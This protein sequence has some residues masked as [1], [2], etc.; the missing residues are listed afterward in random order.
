MADINRDTLRH[1]E[2]PPI[3]AQATDY[4]HPAAISVLA[5]IRGAPFRFEIRGA[6]PRPLS[7]RLP[8]GRYTVFFRGLAEISALYDVRAL[9]AATAMRPVGQFWM[10]LPPGSGGYI[11]GPAIQAICAG[12]LFLK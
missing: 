2:D 5:S 10:F 11:D 6:N 1:A 9:C 7:R 3:W 12:R 8:L 4:S